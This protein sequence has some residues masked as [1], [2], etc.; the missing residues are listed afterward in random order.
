MN[1]AG[2]SMM[3]GFERL[4]A[5]LQA[6]SPGS[7]ILM[8][9]WVDQSSTGTSPLDAS[10]P[11]LATEVNGHRLAVALDEALVPD[12]AAAGG[13][14]H[15]IGHSF[16]ANVATT[17]ALALAERPRQ[18]TLLDSPESELTR[19]G[20]AQNALRYKLPRLDPGRGPGRTFVDNYISA[21][22]ERYSTEPGLDAVVDV[23][24]AP[25]EG[26]LS[27][28]HSF[29]IDVVRRLG[30]R[31]RPAGRVRLVAAHRSRRRI[32]GHVLRAARRGR[33][34]AA[35]PGG[36]SAQPTGRRA[37]GRHDDAA[38]RGGCVDRRHRGHRRR[39]RADHVE[40]DVRDVRRLAVAHVRRAAPGA[41]RRPGHPVRRRPGA[42]AGRHR[43][44]RHGRARV[45]PGPVRPGSRH[46]RAVGDDQRADARPRRPIRR[47]GRP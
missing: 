35:H 27:E 44:R 8:F 34:P 42:L 20:G 16:G 6:A 25:P 3:S 17:A 1:G 21:V 26:D 11:E 22:G 41:A 18:L 19:I 29:A 47:A 45:V 30:R 9:S 38:A 46:P 14:I 2:Q 28:K 13:R 36:G 33:A 40:R 23:R 31:H 39:G 37:P 24:T 43:R 32:G 12:F 10:G 5:A 7:S 4:A 15:L